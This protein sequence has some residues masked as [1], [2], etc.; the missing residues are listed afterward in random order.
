MK[1]KASGG[2]YTYEMAKK[3]IEAGATRIGTSKS[4]EI[5]KNQNYINGS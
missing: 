3:L 5:I 2:I 4:I 1:I